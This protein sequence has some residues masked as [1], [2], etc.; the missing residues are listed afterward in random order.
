M[1]ICKGISTQ[2]H[3]KLILLVKERIT[4]KFII[5]LLQLWLKAGIMENNKV[6]NNL[7]GTPQGGV[8]SPLLAQCVR[9]ILE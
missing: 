8:I 9:Q 4:D 6:R 5:K 3:D 1:Q 2:F 7:L